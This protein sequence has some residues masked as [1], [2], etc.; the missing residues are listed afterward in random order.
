VKH[1]PFGQCKLAALLEEFI[2]VRRATV[3]LFLNLDEAAWT[4]RGVANKNEVS[5]RALAYIIAGHELHHRRIL[6]EKYFSSI[7]S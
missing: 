3:L 4:R 2:A 7:V 5:V 1:A 6:G